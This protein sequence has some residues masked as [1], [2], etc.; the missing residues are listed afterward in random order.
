MPV[1]CVNIDWLEVYVFEPTDR[2]RDEHYFSSLGYIVNSREYGTPMYRSMFTIL[3][4]DNR[5][6]YEV[7]RDPYSVRSQGG[8]FDDGACH[9]RLTNRE[10]YRPHAVELLR[11]F[12]LKHGYTFNGISRFDLA[13]DFNRFDNGHDPADF[14]RRYLAGYYHK[15]GLSRVRLYGHDFDGGGHV[16]RVGNKIVKSATV[17][18]LGHQV[19][20]HGRDKMRQLVFN[21][22]KWGSPSSQVSV[23]LY[24]KTLE[25][26]EVKEKFYIRDAWKAAGLDPEKPV[27]RLEFSVSSHAKNWVFAG[28]GE[29]Y[30]LTLG[31]LESYEGLHFLWSCLAAKYFV[32]TRREVT[33][34]GT[35]QRKD[36]TARYMPF[37][38][39]E[40]SPFFPVQLTSDIEPKRGMDKFASDLYKFTRDFQHPAAERIK[41]QD[42]LNYLAVFRLYK[43]PE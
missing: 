3:G 20:V 19:A 21:S 16:V 2:P 1:R 22:A 6:M 30:R 33:R 28:G 27:W 9:I 17:E 15:I 37:N 35:E 24:D 12:L 23:K 32:F 42:I 11:N 41:A 38:V 4:D 25:L 43:P 10:C 18:H 36:R 31:T 7:R 14:L 34:T 40:S 5:P 39:A 13:A 8:I 29:V 26:H